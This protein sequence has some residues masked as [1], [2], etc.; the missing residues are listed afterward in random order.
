MTPAA[1]PAT[2]T[3]AI[4]LALLATL[5]TAAPPARAQDSVLTEQD[6]TPRAKTLGITGLLVGGALGYGFGATQKPPAYSIA[7]G[8]ALLGGLAGY[9]VGRQYDELHAAQ[10]HG[11]RPIA[12]RTSEAELEGDPTALAVHDDLIAVGG[13]EGVQLFS[14]GG[15]SLLP[16]GTRAGGLLGISTVEITPRTGWLTI[17]AENGL[18]IFPPRRGRGVLVN[19]GS[20]AAVIA[21]SG[22]IFSA[23][24]DRVIVTPVGA[25]SAQPWPNT[26]LGAPVRALAIDTARAIIWAATDKQLIALQAIGD[27]LVRLGAAAIDGGARRVTVQGD[28]AAVAV[29]ER[30]VRIFDVS[31]PRRPLALKTWTVARFAYDVSLDGK[32]M[33]VAAGPEGVYVADFHGK[34]LVTIGLARGLGFASAIVSR[35]GYTYLLDRRTNTLRRLA[36]D[37]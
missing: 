35:D 23:S 2:R 18:Y 33:F 11:V 10:F 19:P 29:G 22:R 17:G 34:N 27:S 20:V 3:A 6:R 12:P 36:S 31:D 28:I 37:F 32:R 13:N 9:F 1:P 21:T 16:T 8:A 30:G 5:A 14:S 26:D 15:G 25:D 4:G 7:V 24:G